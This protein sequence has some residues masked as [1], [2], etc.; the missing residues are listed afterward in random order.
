MVVVYIIAGVL[1]FLAIILN[2]K[3]TNLGSMPSFSLKSILIWGARIGLTLLVLWMSYSLYLYVI[4]YSKGK[5][6]N[7]KTISCNILHISE[8]ISDTTYVTFN[9]EF[10]IET[11][12]DSLYFQF[13]RKEEYG[14][15]W[16]PKVLWI[17]KGT[18]D[19]V[20]RETGKECKT[21]RGPGP[22]K[23][24]PL[25]PGKSVWLRIYEKTTCEE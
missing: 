24:W 7:K 11:Q 4:N 20:A 23:A 17:G 2:T 3:K 21:C 13:P 15:D 1:V 9:Y 10:E 16:L 14:G 19:L 12:G 25:K 6:E 22:V 18:Y 8:V 5:D